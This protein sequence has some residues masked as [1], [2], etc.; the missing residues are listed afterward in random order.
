V[1]SE[2][3]GQKE[4]WRSV[5]T[6]LE[7]PRF[8]SVR[9]LK[10]NVYQNNP[11]TIGVEL[12]AA[13]TVKIREIPKEA[14]VRVTL[15]STSVSESFLFEFYLNKNLGCVILREIDFHLKICWSIPCFVESMYVFEW[16]TILHDV[17]KFA[18]NDVEAIWSIFWNEHDLYA[19]QPRLT[20]TWG[21]IVQRL[22]FAS[23][24]CLEILWPLT[25][26]NKIYT[27]S[28]F[29]GSPW[30]QTTINNKTMDLSKCYQRKLKSL[31]RRSETVL[32][33][34]SVTFLYIATWFTNISCSW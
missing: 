1:I 23:N 33:V 26:L 20:E 3:A 7:F 24:K 9:Y 14:C 29:V 32:I 30:T 27:G 19:K 12:N 6:G 13:I 10:D 16:L 4:V 5:D 28:V 15:K 8:L 11:Q 17:C 18:S 34:Q 22:E 21:M 31:L 2:E 25:R